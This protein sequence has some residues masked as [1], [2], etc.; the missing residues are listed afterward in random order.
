M[1]GIVDSDSLPLNVNRENLQQK[2]TIST[3]GGKLL[4]KVVDMLV[5]FNPSPPTEEDELFADE[6]DKS[7]EEEGFASKYEK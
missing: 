7:Y 3:I 2:K 5:N 4:K 6:E 1:K